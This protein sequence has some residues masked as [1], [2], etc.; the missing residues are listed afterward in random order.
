VDYFKRRLQSWIAQDLKT[1][2]WAEFLLLTQEAPFHSGIYPLL[3]QVIVEKVIASSTLE[4]ALSYID[5]LDK[6]EKMLPRERILAIENRVIIYN[7]HS[8][9]FG[10]YNYRNEKFVN[11][12]RESITIL[13]AFLPNSE[14]E[15]DIRKLTLFQ[16]LTVRVIGTIL[17]SSL[18]KS[19]LLKY[20]I[21]PS[22]RLYITSMFGKS[23]PE[24]PETS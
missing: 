3:V 23:L 8:W 20:D 14:Q 4:D 21:S 15:P 13:C 24:I 22:L 12:V 5:L 2:D 6:A 1:V 18:V 11:E 16:R 19:G 7:M 10:R 9:I 17:C